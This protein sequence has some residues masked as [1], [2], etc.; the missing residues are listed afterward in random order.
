MVQICITGQRQV[1]A[2]IR[3]R[4][5]EVVHAAVVDVLALP[6]DKRFHRFYP[7]D[8]E[9]FPV[10]PGRS[11]QYTIIEIRLFAGRSTAT[12]KALYARLYADA[13]RHLGIEAVDLEIALV[14][15][16]R[17]DW[18]I[19]GLPGDELELTYQVQR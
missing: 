18:A 11:A 2:P 17:H 9:D 16:P 12:K 5:S 6:P 15:T 13:A 10:P 3:A 14:E 8:P 19:R 1:L 4:F 7:L